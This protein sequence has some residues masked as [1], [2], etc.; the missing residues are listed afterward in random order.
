MAV[1]NAHSVL[2]PFIMLL[3][4]EVNV[5]VKIPG[6]ENQLAIWMESDAAVP[7]ERL[8]PRSGDA[9]EYVAGCSIQQVVVAGFLHILRRYEYAGS[10]RTDCQA[11][12]E[13]VAERMNG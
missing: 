12:W 7:P 1:A 11:L 10:R 6:D 3:P 9:T 4:V 13:R 2:L 5:D 8:R